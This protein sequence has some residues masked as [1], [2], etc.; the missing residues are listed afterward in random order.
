MKSSKFVLFIVLAFIFFTVTVFVSCTK[1]TDATPR[2]P[3]PPPILYGDSVAFSAKVY[4]TTTTNDI[5]D[6]YLLGDSM[7]IPQDSCILTKMAFNVQNIG[8]YTTKCRF[9][10]NQVE[11]RTLGRPKYR[12]IGDDST[13]TFY[14]TVLLKKG[15]NF[16][17]FTG[18]SWA[19]AKIYYRI[20]PG[21]VS[22]YNPN[23]ADTMTVIGLPITKVRKYQ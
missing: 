22:I 4:P 9:L 18:F 16:F 11:V 3:P 15:W 6:P 13:F 23:H 21:D 8:G 19:P 10:I 14:D 2:V 5:N 20:Y 17:K 7:Y 1:G 12:G